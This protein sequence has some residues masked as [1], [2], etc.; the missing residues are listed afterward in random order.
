MAHS[1]LKEKRR[2]KRVSILL[3]STPREHD[4]A[5][6]QVGRP[7]TPQALLI[8]EFFMNYLSSFK[9]LSRSKQVATVLLASTLAWAIGLP[10][11]FTT[12]SAAQLSQIS[13]TASSSVP[14][15]ATNYTIRFTSTT[16]VAG[17]QTMSIQF[18]PTTNGFSFS[19]LVWSDIIGTGMTVVSGCTASP[20]EVTVGFTNDPD[21]VT[22]T[23]CNDGDT[24][25]PGA[26]VLT[27]TN[28]RI[29]NPA[30]PGSYIVRI[31]GTQTD[32]GDTRVAI[33]NQVTVTASVDTTLTFTVAGV[34]SGQT[35]N[36]ET[37]STTT[38]ATAIGFGTLASG[39]PVLAAQDLT[40]TT[41]AQNGFIVTVRQD[42][43]LLSSNGADID[44][45]Q[46]GANTATPIAWTGPA[47]TLGSEN[48]YGHMG[49]TSDD[50]D[51]NAN[52]FY[53]G[54]VIKYAGNFF[55]T[56]T[57][58]IFSHNA[59]SDGTTQ[60]IGKAR[61]GYKIQVSA[62]QEAATDYTNRLIYVCTPTF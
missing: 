48:T 28:N 8:I 37:I 51:L 49:L 52:E 2:V 32:R 33:V 19:G 45:F 46:D 40:V 1:L 36:G 12:A 62:L 17:G 26:K 6:H 35:I 10:A 30:T 61:V 56:T 14:S 55:A 11:F 43:N 3:Y 24:I 38:T 39:T 27:F 22:L 13:A 53:S 4:T 9:S 42:Q 41:N 44:T 58:T 59:P 31:A 25:A 15:V 16:T 21:V 47:A 57:R 60:N 20:N 50:T 34:A 23:V 5:G 54:A 7:R 18:D 29:T